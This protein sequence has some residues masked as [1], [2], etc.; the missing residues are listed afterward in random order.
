LS[1]QYDF[2]IHLKRT[3][4]FFNLDFETIRNRDLR[5]EHLLQVLGPSGVEKYDGVLGKFKWQQRVEKRLSAK[6]VYILGNSRGNFIFNCQR[7]V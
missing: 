2:F 3:L 5:D 6:R 4:C 1:I 7:F